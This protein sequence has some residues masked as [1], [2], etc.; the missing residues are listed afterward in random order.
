MIIVAV[1]V[2]VVGIIVGVVLA[3][4]VIVVVRRVGCLIYGIAFTVYTKKPEKKR[5]G[6]GA[7]WE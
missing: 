4:I 5:R 6:G 1:C 7:D 2:I 3:I